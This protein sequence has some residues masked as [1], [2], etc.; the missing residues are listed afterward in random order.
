MLQYYPDD[1]VSTN[2]SR[3]ANNNNTTA[4]E[5]Q[6]VH[7]YPNPSKGELN[8]YFK[9]P[10]GN[11]YTLELMNLLGK[12]IYKKVVNANVD[13]LTLSLNDV[14]N[15]IYICRITDSN[16]INLYNDKLII[17]K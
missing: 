13:V 17:I 9:Q 7:V 6:I 4:P 16:N 3:L 8:I 12:T 5:P 10:D 1:N 15:G 2:K 11:N 14:P